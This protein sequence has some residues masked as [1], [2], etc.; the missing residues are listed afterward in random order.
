MP[1]KANPDATTTARRRTIAAGIASVIGTLSLLGFLI[2]LS[3]GMYQV[4]NSPNPKAELENRPVLRVVNSAWHALYSSLP[5]GD[6]KPTYVMPDGNQVREDGT[7]V[8]SE[9]PRQTD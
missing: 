2:W 8:G 4:A 1:L 3:V 9:A 6:S 5:G 7:I